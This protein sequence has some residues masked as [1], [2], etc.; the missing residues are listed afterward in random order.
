MI[1]GGQTNVRNP[2]GTHMTAPGAPATAGSDKT[3]LFAVLG[4]VLG[5]LCCG[6][7]GIVFAVLS[8][9]QSKQHGSSPTLPWVAIAIAIV[10]TLWQ[11]GATVVQ[12][13]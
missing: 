2:G 9:N 13:G 6:P 1:C 4:I 10:G 8:L 11:L 12:L 7:A 5:L 3:T